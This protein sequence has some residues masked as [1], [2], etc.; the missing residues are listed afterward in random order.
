M[1]IKNQR[2]LLQNIAAGL[3]KYDDTRIGSLEVIFFRNRKEVLRTDVQTALDYLAN[4]IYWNECGDWSD[5][6]HAEVSVM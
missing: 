6:T 4:D 5:A 3:N 1:H 2:V